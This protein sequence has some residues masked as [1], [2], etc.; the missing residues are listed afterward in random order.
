MG[1]R[2]AFAA[3]AIAL[4]ATSA[5]AFAQNANPNPFPDVPPDHWAAQAV[6]TL[7]DR[8]IV[9]GYPDGTYGGPKAMTRY[10]FAM[11]LSRLLPQITAEI[12]AAIAKIPP[13]PQPGVTQDQLNQAL[14]NYYTKAEADQRFATKAEVDQLR[15]LLDQFRNELTALGVDVNALKTRLAV[16]EAR[17]AELEKLQVYG[18]GTA[19][20]KTSAQYYGGGRGQVNAGVDQDGG[21]LDNGAAINANPW[22]IT[23]GGPGAASLTGNAALNADGKRGIFENPSTLFDTQLGIQY[24]PSRNLRAV[25]EFIMGNYWGAWENQQAFSSSFG[26]GTD[27]TSLL[28]NRPGES[29]GL[30][31][32][33]AYLAVPFNLPVFPNAIGNSGIAIGRIPTKLTRFTWWAVDPDTT[34]DVPR[35]DSGNITGTGLAFAGK[36]GPLNVT[37]FGVY[38][39]TDGTDPWLTQNTNDIGRNGTIGFGHVVRPGGQQLPGMGINYAN[40]TR[41][42][43]DVGNGL[44]YWTYYQI[45][46]LNDAA[47]VRLALPWIGVNYVIGT[48]DDWQNWL[49]TDS[50]TG[51]S[52]PYFNRTG[53]VGS[54]DWNTTVPVHRLVPVIPP[55]G[56]QGEVA[57]SKTNNSGAFGVESSGAIGA[58]S[59]LVNPILG[60]PGVALGTGVVPSN[61]GNATDYKLTFGIGSAGLAFG[62][63]SI[64][65]GFDAPGYWG[66]MGSWVNPWNYVSDSPVYAKGGHGNNAWNV[67]I[68]PTEFGLGLPFTNVPLL[69][70]LAFNL[71]TGV[72]HLA[73]DAGGLGQTQFFSQ[74]SP[75]SGLEQISN[76]QYFRISHASAGLSFGAGPRSGYKFGVSAEDVLRDYPAGGS[77]KNDMTFIWDALKN[78]VNV[79]GGTGAHQISPTFPV[80]NAANSSETVFTPANPLLFPGAIQSDENYYKL[81]IGKNLTADGSA[82]AKLSFERIVYND[83]LGTAGGSYRGAL[84]TMQVTYKF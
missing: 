16:D 9:I 43:L 32:Y 7:Q 48:G 74:V 33:L 35:E 26:P 30:Q 80:S 49:A 31:T 62:G 72:G 22:G 59:T 29:L 15:G 19:I 77:F 6:K 47:G 38:Q 3:G 24:T 67:P 36:A 42:H 28:S 71:Q 78:L 4:V 84:G 46:T 81:S 23:S 1:K 5:P 63:K 54:V 83:R 34:V 39:P 68:I 13:P 75:S 56:F 40:Q 51:A 37:L 44:D 69:G 64:S 79:K 21:L 66:E 8:G 17:I 60:G 61:V 73:Q 27:A 58:G 55:I 82:T 25:A 12:D 18:Y 14:Q 52:F 2:A 53:Q 10:E 45:P 11:A 70:S 20:W 76:S 57:M 50:A 41:T 65:P